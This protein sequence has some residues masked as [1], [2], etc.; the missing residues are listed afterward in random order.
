V[1][2]K[3][4]YTIYI[5]T[6]RETVKYLK[7][8][9]TGSST[10]CTALISPCI[11]CLNINLLSVTNDSHTSV[12]TVSLLHLHWLILFV[13]FNLFSVSTVVSVDY[14]CSQLPIPNS[15][16]DASNS[17]GRRNLVYLCHGCSAADGLE[18]SWNHPSSN[19]RRSCRYR[20]TN[21]FVSL[22]HICLLYYYCSK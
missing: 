18:R 7:F 21:R 15:R 3:F 1:W 11:S 16:I 22:R 17:G 2:P 6:D 20:K 5:K 9:L 13:T 14:C 12:I 8:L 4:L 10:I 19:C